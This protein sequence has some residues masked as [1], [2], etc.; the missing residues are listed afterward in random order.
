MLT[1]LSHSKLE[2]LRLCPL[3]AYFD[4]VIHAPQEPL[5]K[6]YAASGKVTHKSIEYC[7]INTLDLL[8]NPDHPLIIEDVI[9]HMSLATQQGFIKYAQQYSLDDDKVDEIVEWLNN[10]IEF[11]YRRYEYCEKKE[12]L[13]NFMPTI[14]EK[15]YSMYINDILYRGDIDI[16]FEDNMVWLIDWKT[17]ADTSINQEQIRQATRYVMLYNENH[18]DQIDQCFF[19]NLRNRVNLNKALIKVTPD[20]IEEQKQEII[21]QYQ[22]HETDTGSADLQIAFLSAIFV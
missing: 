22:V 9:E 6:D 8:N 19:V 10:F 15:R 3:S 21:A 17:N 2:Q 16:V 11:M 13:C 4:N 20:M 1:K 5:F 7:F 14:L 12:C 18:L